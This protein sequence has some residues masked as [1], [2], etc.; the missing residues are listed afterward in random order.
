MLEAEGVFVQREKRMGKWK[1]KGK[2]EE[3]SLK[4]EII[5]KKVNRKN[6]P[7]HINH[8]FRNNCFHQSNNTILL[9]K[10]EELV[11]KIR[12]QL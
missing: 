5:K 9:Q 7:C 11:L 12:C 8:F 1:G 2:N 3:R 4:I 10:G 6:Y